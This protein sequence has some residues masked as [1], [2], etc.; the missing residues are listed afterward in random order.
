MGG[1]GWGEGGLVRGMGGL[2]DG[3]EDVV[4]G[5]GGGVLI[6]DGGGE[7]GELGGT[8]GTAA[9][10]GVGG[11]GGEMVGGGVALEGGLAVGGLYGGLAVGGP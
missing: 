4:A 1:A 5:E 2:A 11:E 7:G 3:G 9:T 10:K 6:R 8:S